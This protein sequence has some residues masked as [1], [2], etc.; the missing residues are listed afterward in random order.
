MVGLFLSVQPFLHSLLLY[1]HTETDTQIKLYS[2][3]AT[4]VTI[5]LIYALLSG[6]TAYAA[7]NAPSVGREQMNTGT[8]YDIASG[9]KLLT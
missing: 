5:G 6:D 2:L 7:F 3:P 8:R 1:E 9:S 4:S